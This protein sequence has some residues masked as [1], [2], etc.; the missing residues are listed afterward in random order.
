MRKVI[1]IICLLLSFNGYSQS[2]GDKLRK[3][4]KLEKAIIAYKSD[5]IKNPTD[6]KNTYK[7]ATTIALTYSLNDSAFHYLKIALKDDT[8]L[9]CLSDNDFISLTDDA[10]WKEIENLQFSKYQSKE[11]TLKSPEYAK[12]LLGLIM[13]DQALDYQI[14]MAKAHYMK[15]GSIPHWYYPIS[16]MK[17]EITVGNFETMERLF[18]EY[19]WPTY[20][21]VGKLAA[22]APLLII[23]HH[24]KEEIRIKYLGKIKNACFEKEGSCMEYAKINDRILVNT[25]QL[26][27]YGMQFKYDENRKLIPFPIK[28]PEYVDQRRFEIG[29]EPIAVYL[30][31]KIKYEWTITQKKK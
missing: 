8:S 22:D 27:T 20:S 15:N 17:S 2:D 4:G 30:K 19:G 14:D 11:G 24:E 18:K 6:S 16:K 23:N 1:Y 3:E 9:W 12:K 10:R 31:R 5:F 28:D 21:V 29:L 26:Q 25:D 7:L 13:K